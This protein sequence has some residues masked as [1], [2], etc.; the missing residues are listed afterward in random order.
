M[1][2]IKLVLLLLMLG[3]AGGGFVYVKT[4]KADLAVSEANN[5]ALTSAVA[6]NE[7]AITSLKADYKKLTDELQRVN[8]EFA[9]SRAQND[10]LKDKL[11]KVDLGLLAQE[12]PTTV[13]RLINKGTENA[14]RCFEILSGAPLTDQERKATDGKSF[15]KEC[16]WL[17]PGVDATK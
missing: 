9:A 10:I 4:L 12:K 8:A 11:S 1:G 17:W 7:E 16:P 13:E 6:T 15:N 2:S 3:G 5:A 14:G